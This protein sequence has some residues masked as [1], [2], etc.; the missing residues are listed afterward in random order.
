MIKAN[1]FLILIDVLSSSKTSLLLAF[2]VNII[3]LE[4][5]MDISKLFSLRILYIILHDNISPNVKTLET[6]FLV[7]SSIVEI[8]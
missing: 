6:V 3:E 1:L 4:S 5:I 8:A 2:F 7:T